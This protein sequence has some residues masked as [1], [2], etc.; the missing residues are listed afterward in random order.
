MN[1][2]FTSAGRRGYLI[3]YFKQELSGK[4]LVHAA[5][6]IDI[7]SAFLEADFSVITPLIYDKS[8]ISFLINYCRDN[9]IKAIIPLFDIDLPVLAAHESD[10]Q[11]VG[12]TLVCSS[13]EVCQICND[14]FRTYNFLK[15]NRINVPQ[16]Y[17]SLKDAHAALKKGILNFPIIVKP[18][19]GMGSIG[20]YVAENLDELDVFLKKVKRDIEKSYLKYESC[21]EIN[22]AVL[23]QQ[24]LKGQQYLLDVVND[25]NGAYVTT[26][27]KEQIARHSG[28]ANIARTVNSELLSNLGRKISMSLGHRANLDVDV[29]LVDNKPYVLEMNA[30]FGGAYPFSHLAGAN[31]P[32]AILSWLDGKTANPNCFVITEDI[33]GIKNIEPCRW[34]KD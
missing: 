16:T 8:Y 11:E 18:R 25:L 24:M 20:V 17:I 5:N 4:G 29:F 14:K 32:K 30:R 21:A 1:I 7:N 22:S 33:T 12:V 23:V 26:F 10:F 15:D 31:L 27:V 9:A 28:E 13:Q 34:S 6:S 2:L 3:R 19:W